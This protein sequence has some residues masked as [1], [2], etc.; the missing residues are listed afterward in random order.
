MGSWASKA[1]N[2]LISAFYGGQ[3]TQVVLR[4]NIT[5]AGT[6]RRQTCIDTVSL[7]IIDH[8]S[9]LAFSGPH[10]DAEYTKLL[11]MLML[12]TPCCVLCTNT[13]QVEI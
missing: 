13:M 5:F 4:P 9:S 2:V 10:S 6:L 12:L 1:L 7:G 3:R 8:W 11:L